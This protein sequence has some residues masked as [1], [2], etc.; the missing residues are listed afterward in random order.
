MK[1]NTGLNSNNLKWNP[2]RCFVTKPFHI[3]SQ[4]QNSHLFLLGIFEKWN[5]IFK[6]ERDFC[7]IYRNNFDRS[8]SGRMRRVCNCETWG[9]A[10]QVDLCKA[11]SFPHGHT[12]LTLKCLESVS[13][14]CLILEACRPSALPR[15]SEP[16]CSLQ[17]TCCCWWQCSWG[18]PEEIH[19][20][21]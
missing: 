21:D 1:F 15:D 14:V 18:G 5:Y 4:D 9:S 2:L 16:S 6:Q 3:N 7:L 19:L 12:A 10:S 20:V 13:H 11:I 17:S 8:K